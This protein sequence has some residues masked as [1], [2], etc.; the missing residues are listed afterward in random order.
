[1]V[2]VLC[3][4]VLIINLPNTEKSNLT[5]IYQFILFFFSGGRGGGGTFLESPDNFLGPEGCFMFAV[6]AV[7]IK[8][9]IILKIIQ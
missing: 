8:V 2:L 3:I 9:S 4:N 6:Y 7:K 5:I 1:M